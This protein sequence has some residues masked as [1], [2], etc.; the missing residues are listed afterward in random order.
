MSGK[1]SIPHYSLG[2]YIRIMLITISLLA[3]FTIGTGLNAIS[4]VRKSYLQSADYTFGTY[5]KSLS[6]AQSMTLHQLNASVMDDILMDDIVE[7]ETF[8]DKTYAFELLRS[9]FADNN[10]YTGN[11]A[12]YILYTNKDGNF[13]NLSQLNETYDEY[14]LKCEYIKCLYSSDQTSHRNGSFKTIRL[15]D[16]PILAYRISYKERTLAMFVQAQDLFSPLT[17]I[18][19]GK[20]G[21]LVIRDDDGEIFYTLGSATHDDT[22]ISSY[23]LNSAGFP[24]TVTMYMDELDLFSAILLQQFIIIFVIPILIVITAILLFRMYQKIIRPIRDFSEKLTLIGTID[25]DTISMIENAHIDELSSTGSQFRN[26]YEELKKLKIEIYEKELAQ[27]RMEII[28]L[29]QQIRPHFYLNCLTTIGSMTRLGKY[30]EVQDMILFTSRYLRYLFQT[31]KDFLD[32]KQELDHVNA[33]MDIQ[34][35][36][37]QGAFSYRVNLPG[38]LERVMIPPLV[39]ITF[40]E[41]CIK[42]NDIQAMNLEIEINVEKKENGISITIADN[43]SGFTNEYLETFSQGV[44]SSA[45]SSFNSVTRHVGIRNCINR[46]DLLYH[47]KA[48]VKLSNKETKGAVVEILLPLENEEEDNE[49]TDS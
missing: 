13:Y 26:L 24:F 18:P 41:N 7:P 3:V 43:G 37:Y 29:R 31:D 28:F 36:R 6:A 49:N 23:Q 48:V 45:Y 20:R 32:I 30:T 1:T 14:L 9:R 12:L 5:T 25:E 21:G 4:N 40:A 39:L 17:D 16:V 38:E 19:Y 34:S 11:N 33:Y 2:R 27:N 46:L 22:F 15:D 42:H 10:Y 47:G 35:L 8:R 44:N